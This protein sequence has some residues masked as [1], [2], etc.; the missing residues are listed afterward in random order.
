MCAFSRVFYRATHVTTWVV[1][2]WHKPIADTGFGQQMAG[3]GGIAFQLLTKMS[4]I[5]TQIVAV[6]HRIR[7]PHLIQQL[8][9]R[10]HFSGIVQQQT[11]QAKL[12]GR[13]VNFLFVT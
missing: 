10:Q 3:L 9:L 7:P 4:H 6:L 8:T 1:F 13:Q 11:Q 2:L 12:G 5:N